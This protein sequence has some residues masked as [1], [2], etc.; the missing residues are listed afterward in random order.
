MENSCIKVRSLN[1]ITYGHFN[2]LSVTS[3]VGYVGKVC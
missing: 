3:K 1:S 2:D